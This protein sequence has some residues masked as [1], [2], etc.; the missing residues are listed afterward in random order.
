MPTFAPRGLALF[1]LV[2]APVALAA[3]GVRAAKTPSAAVEEFMRALADSNLSRMAELWG[4]AKGPA[5]RTHMPKTYEKQIVIIQAMLHGVQA[6]ALGDVPSDKGD[7]RTVT[8]QLSHNGCKV[9]I[10]INVVKAK[11]GWLVHDF[12]LDQAA[13]VNRPCDAAGR[14]G[15]SPE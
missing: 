13:E 1:L 7:M 14:P 10:P 15:N 8:T 5:A 6:Q 3:Q 9:T 12:K 11:E 2:G 4:N